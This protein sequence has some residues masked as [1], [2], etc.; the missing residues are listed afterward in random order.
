MRFAAGGRADQRGGRRGPFPERV[1]KGDDPKEQNERML[2][3]LFR[4]QPGQRLSFS[5]NRGFMRSLRQCQAVC[6]QHK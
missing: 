3:Q 6:S 4:L 5:F 2:Q 1:D